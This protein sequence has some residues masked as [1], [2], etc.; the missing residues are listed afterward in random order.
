MTKL[1]IVDLKKITGGGLTGWGIAAIGAFLTFVSGF[2]DGFARP[3][4]C[5]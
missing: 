4:K 1:E 5:N 2:I 3:F